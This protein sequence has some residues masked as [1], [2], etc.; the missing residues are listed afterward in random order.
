M[1]FLTHGK[2]EPIVKVENLSN[3]EQ[4]I[5]NGGIQKNSKSKTQSADYNLRPRC[6]GSG[7]TKDLTTLAPRTEAR[8]ETRNPPCGGRGVRVAEIL[9]L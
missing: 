4:M 3:L 1:E 5:R 2:E 8:N 7:K 6:E 9:R